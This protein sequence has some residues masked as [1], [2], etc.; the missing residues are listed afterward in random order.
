MSTSHNTAYWSVVGF[1]GQ[2]LMPL[3]GWI[4]AAQAQATGFS[5]APIAEPIVSAEFSA[6]AA[7]L[8]AHRTV[9]EHEV[10]FV[11]LL[12]P[13]ASSSIDLS[14]LL[15]G[16]AAWPA[17]AQL[18]QGVLE[19]GWVSAPIDSSFFTVLAGGAVG[20]DALFTDTGDG[21]VNFD[22][23]NPFVLALSDP[24]GYQTAYPECN[25]RNGDC[26]GDGDVDFDD[27]N[28]FVALLSGA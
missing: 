16:T 25:L 6:D 9:V 14:N 7:A 17:P 15:L 21:V 11:R 10:N 5:Y 4:L 26:D 13:S 19:T 12:D 18:A 24:A 2:L 20:L 8:V 22:D 28:P 3:L 1:R 23:I 27:I